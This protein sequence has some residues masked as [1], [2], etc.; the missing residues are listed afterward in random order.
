MLEWYQPDPRSSIVGNFETK[1]AF[2][3]KQV[4]RGHFHASVPE[5]IVKSYKTVEYL[6]AHAWYHWPMFDEALR[7]LLGMVEMA[8][9][10]RCQAF[11]IPVFKDQLDK[12]GNKVPTPLYTLIK[13]LIEK[14][15]EK[16]LTEWLKIIRK[17]RNHFAHPQNHEFMGASVIGKIKNLINLI[18]LIFLDEAEYIAASTEKARLEMELAEFK[19]GLFVFESDRSGFLITE[20]RLLEVFKVMGEW[21]YICR[22]EPVI[23]NF[24]ND[25]SQHRF[26]LPLIL[27]LTHPGIKDGV[28]EAADLKTRSGIKL[29]PT[30]NPEHYELF[31]QYRQEWE[32]VE[33]KNQLIYKSYMINKSGGEVRDIMYEHRWANP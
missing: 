13:Q 29:Y 25:F 2:A 5:D 3:E 1:E 8:I 23:L 22:I 28:L 18:N 14:E 27:T 12:E 4:V 24:R 30:T 21:V 10:I 17:L 11:Q 33:E 15:P 16:G 32:G 6:M 19:E 7:K 26:P 9:R 20:I 31:S